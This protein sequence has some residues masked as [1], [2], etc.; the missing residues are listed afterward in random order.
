MILCCAVLGCPVLQGRHWCSRPHCQAVGAL[1]G[2][3]QQ[4]PQQRRSGFG[5]AHSYA[6]RPHRQHLFAG[7]H[8]NHHKQQQQRQQRQLLLCPCKRQQR[9]H[10]QDVGPRQPAAAA[11]CPC[12]GS[13]STSISTSRSRQH[14]CAR[15]CSAGRTFR[16]GLCAAA[17]LQVPFGNPARPQRRSHLTPTLRWGRRQRHSQQRRHQ[18]GVHRQCV[19]PAERREGQQGEAVGRCRGQGRLRG[20]M[21]DAAAGAACAGWAAPPWVCD[22]DDARQCPGACVVEDN[23]TCISTGLA[24][25]VHVPQ[26]ST[27]TSVQYNT[28]AAQTY[29]KF[30]GAASVKLATH[31]SCTDTARSPSA[32]IVLTLC[33]VVS[34]AAAVLWVVCRS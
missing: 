1:P 16:V 22:G 21:A 29:L 31:V 28:A 23:T 30:E 14:P 33:S 25:P 9:P 5:P 32:A 18:H 3:R 6:A 34:F 26:C 20:N 13:I 8:P 11:S 17:G 24:A 15:R 10:H 2:W 27:C 7:L 19:W 12:D 4:P